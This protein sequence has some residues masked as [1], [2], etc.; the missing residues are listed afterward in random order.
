MNKLCKRD[1]VDVVVGTVHSG[2][3]LAMAKAACDNNA[4]LIIPN[5]GADAITSPMCAPNIFRTSFSKSQ[6]GL[7]MGKEA[8]GK[9]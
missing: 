4:L 2:V 1:N 3:S 7:A 6:P 5:A 9:G 8:V